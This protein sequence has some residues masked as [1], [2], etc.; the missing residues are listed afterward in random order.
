[1]LY[2]SICQHWRELDKKKKR[3]PTNRKNQNQNQPWPTICNS[4]LAIKK[5]DDALN[6][7]DDDD[8]ALRRGLQKSNI[9]QFPD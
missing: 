5:P 8:E 7:D 2:G 6:D 3:T 4:N 1:M 9:A